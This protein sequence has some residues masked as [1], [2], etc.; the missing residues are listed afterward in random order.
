MFGLNRAATLGLIAMVATTGCSGKDF[1]G[2]AGDVSL[3]EN[4]PP[5]V[6]PAGSSFIRP[7]WSENGHLAYVVPDLATA[8][9]RPGGTG[10]VRVLHTVAAPAQLS[11]VALSPDASQWYTVTI[12]NGASVLR[13]HHDGIVE[14]LTD[15]GSSGN[16]GIK[17]G[18]GVVVAANGDVAFIARPDSLFLKRGDAAPRFVAAGCRTIAA[19]SS[20]GDGVI[21]HHPEHYSNPLRFAMDGT[22]AHVTG[23]ES[24]GVITDLQWTAQGVHLLYSLVFSNFVAERQSDPPS[25]FSTPAV[26]YPETSGFDGVLAADGR[27]FVYANNYCAKSSGFF[28]CDKNQTILYHADLVKRTTKRVVVHT[29]YGGVGLSIS[30]DGRRIAYTLDNQ[31][32]VIPVP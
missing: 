28:G 14:V 3:P 9:A 26:D 5:A 11:A 2:P 6:G 30:P 21:C 18:R 15:H 1:F 8:V 13:W 27:S 25:K 29:S 10:P 32:Y 31:L 22:V 16:Y 19:V 7:T 23:S 20:A 4:H 24:E 17:Y 12:E